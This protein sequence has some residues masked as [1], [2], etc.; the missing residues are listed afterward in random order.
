MAT[1]TVTWFSDKG[2]GFIAPDDAHAHDL[3]V[4]H[5]GM[6]GERNGALAE[7]ARVSYDARSGATGLKAVNVELM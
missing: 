4:H 6:T 1:G 3:F 2:Y 7:G 5:A